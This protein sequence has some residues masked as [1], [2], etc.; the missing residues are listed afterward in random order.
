MTE[1]NIELE[2]IAFKGLVAVEDG[3]KSIIEYAELKKPGVE[4]TIEPMKA[5]YQFALSQAANHSENKLIKYEIDKL[6]AVY[7]HYQK[8][9]SKK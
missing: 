9:V 1:K 2:V 3:L 4:I 8:I 5:M 7:S 6:K